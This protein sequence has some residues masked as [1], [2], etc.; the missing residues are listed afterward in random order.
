M[1]LLMTR[2]LKRAYMPSTS[3]WQRWRRQW[4]DVVHVEE[5]PVRDLSVCATILLGLTFTEITIVG[6]LRKQ[7]QAAEVGLQP[8]K[9]VP[10]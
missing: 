10:S 6:P 7:Q 3:T 8:L 2:L 5:L 9:A 1:T 4:R